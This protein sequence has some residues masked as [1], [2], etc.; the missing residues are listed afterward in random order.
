MTSK[1]QMSFNF[2]Q[3][4]FENQMSFN[5]EQPTWEHYF[6]LPDMNNASQIPDVKDCAIIHNNSTHNHRSVEVKIVNKSDNELPEYAHK[7]GDSGMDV[8]AYVP[9]DIEKR[10]VYVYPKYTE[11]V[12][13]GLYV[14]IP[15]G[16]EIQIRPRSGMASKL[17]VTLANCIGTVDSNYRGEIMLIL[18]NFGN[19]RVIIENGDRIGQLVLC[20][21]YNIVWKQID[22]VS[23]FENTERGTGGFGHT[24]V[25]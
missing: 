20:P 2:E 6:M 14:E 10:R 19:E 21:V 18:Y 9:K 8:R 16:Y 12:K 1:N 23:E 15:I 24:G 22:S 3:P 11:I 17:Y 5:F 25:K 4:T 7:F 13:T